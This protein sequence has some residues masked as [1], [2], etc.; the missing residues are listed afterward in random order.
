MPAEDLN[1]KTPGPLDEASR[2]FVQR[3]ANRGDRDESPENPDPDPEINETVLP[4]DDDDPQDSV[5]QADRDT[6]GGS[7][8]RPDSGNLNDYGEDETSTSLL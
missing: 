7:T 5:D 6:E 8:G 1:S 4:L 2:A 3:V